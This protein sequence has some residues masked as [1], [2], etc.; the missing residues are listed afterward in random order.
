MAEA[1]ESPGLHR[2]S[3]AVARSDIPVYRPYSS[4]D[5]VLC[6][7]RSGAICASSAA[8]TPVGC[9]GDQTQPYLVTKSASHGWH[10]SYGAILP[11]DQ[12]C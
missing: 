4:S 8:L 2:C 5:W 6:L 12:L 1:D 10:Q 7:A 9:T 11:S 3:N